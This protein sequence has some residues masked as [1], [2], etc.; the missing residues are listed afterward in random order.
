[1][2]HGVSGLVFDTR[3]TAPVVLLIFL[4]VVLPFCEA[5]Q[6]LFF[7][8]SF[9]TFLESIQA[10]LLLFFAVFS[11]FYMRSAPLPRGQKLFW[12]WAVCWWLVL[13][14]RSTSW[15]RDYFPEVPKVYFRA[16]SIVL[17]LSVLLP[18]FNSTLR[19]EISSKFRT[20]IIPIWGVVLAFAGLIIS[21]SIEHH[22][23]IS[24]LFIHDVANTDMMEELFEFPLIFG[25]FIIAFGL[26]KNDKKL[27]Q[28][29]D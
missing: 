27:A 19:T 3:L 22:R 21:D 26:M 16:I 20:A 1:M 5:Y 17:I 10:L 2:S 6:L 12:L 28:N 14:G 9:V 11:F 13:F 24:S 8:E 15:G 23:F 25:L 29:S 4:I 7:G 18:L